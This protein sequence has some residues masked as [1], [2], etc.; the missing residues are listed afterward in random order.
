MGGIALRETGGS[1]CILHVIYRERGRKEA[2][3]WC[4]SL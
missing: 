4:C 1:F 3:L 2:A